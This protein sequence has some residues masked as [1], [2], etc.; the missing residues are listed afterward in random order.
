MDSKFAGQN[1]QISSNKHLNFPFIFQNQTLYKDL[2]VV[3]YAIVV[4][5]ILI[6]Q[7]T[8]Q[9][10]ISTYYDLFT[11]VSMATDGNTLNFRFNGA[12]CGVGAGAVD[13]EKISNSQF[14]WTFTTEECPPN[15]D[16]NIYFPE[17]DNLL[18]T[19]Q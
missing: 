6:Q 19:K 5:D 3:K 2:L 7:S 8:L 14:N 18:F 12:N 11:I 13:F 4:D 15:A 9:N 16:L 10:T 17:T 1:H